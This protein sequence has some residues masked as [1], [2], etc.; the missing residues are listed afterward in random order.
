MSREHLSVIILFLNTIVTTISARI[1]VVAIA[2]FAV[3][4]SVQI[5]VNFGRSIARFTTNFTVCMARVFI[6]VVSR[7]NLSV[8]NYHFICLYSENIYNDDDDHNRTY[9]CTYVV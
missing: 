9:T 1:I 7:E 2:A 8:L 4:I 3:S 5:C 6:C